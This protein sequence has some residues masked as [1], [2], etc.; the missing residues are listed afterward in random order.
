M[1]IIRDFKA[2]RNEINKV[3]HAGKTVGFVP[4]MGFLHDGHLSLLKEAG[5]QTD[6][7]VM[8]IFV[9]PI[10][11]GAGEDYDEYPRD[12]EQDYRKAEQVG[13]DLIFYPKVKSMYPPGYLTY[14][15]TEGISEP[16]CGG[17]RPGHF[18]GVTTV[19]AKLFNLVTPDK[20]FFGQKD[21]QQALIIRKM[22]ADLNMNPEIVVCPTIREADGLAMS[23]RNAYLDPAE[24]KA[25]TILYR[26]LKKAR[27]MILSGERDA[28]TIRGFMVDSIGKEPLAAIQYIEVVDGQTLQQLECIEGSV[29]LALAVKF[30]ETRLID[31]ISVEV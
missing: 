11:F 17:S 10:Q 4:T 6:Y 25:A 1:Q 23:S 14:V 30:G 16:L 5:R 19:V 15:N 9:N 31:N 27:E 2:L 21:A 24:R 22:V 12:L 26:T 7:V 20:A 29:L 8:S 3:K 28:R 13:C 18:Q